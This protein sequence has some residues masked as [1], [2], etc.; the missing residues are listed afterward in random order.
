MN[1]PNRLVPAETGFWHIDNEEF[2]AQNLFFEGCGCATVNSAVALET[3]G[4][5][6]EFSHGKLLI[7][8]VGADESSEICQPPPW[9]VLQKDD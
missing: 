7:I 8:F 4:S 5:G 9:H 3:R 1:V 2:Q 6:F